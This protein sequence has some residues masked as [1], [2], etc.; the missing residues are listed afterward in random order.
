M[1]V[2]PS[3]I[4]L[5]SLSSL[6]YR[7]IRWEV[8]KRN[9]SGSKMSNELL[10][11][12]SRACSLLKA[13][14]IG[15]EDDLGKWVVNQVKHNLTTQV[16]QTCWLPELRSCFQRKQTRDLSLGM[17]FWDQSWWLTQSSGVLQHFRMSF[18]CYY[19]WLLYQHINKANNY[20]IKVLVN[21]N[22]TLN[23]YTRLKMSSHL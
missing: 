9:N 7:Q 2:G 21:S 8:Q 18:L 22:K 15:L 12:N 13:K 3:R 16:K 10:F 19:L 17:I 11:H 23:S 1:P 6:S 20:T 5:D 4:H 14:V